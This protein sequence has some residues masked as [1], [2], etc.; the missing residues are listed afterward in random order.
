MNAS[1]NA[2][3]GHNDVFACDATHAAQ[4]FGSNTKVP[5]GAELGTVTRNCIFL[6]RM[7]FLFA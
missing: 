1:I 6:P 4:V 2:T 3:G 7:S 5:R